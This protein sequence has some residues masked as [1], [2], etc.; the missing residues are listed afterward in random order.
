MDITPLALTNIVSDAS[1]MAAW[2]NIPASSEFQEA[3]QAAQSPPGPQPPPSSPPPQ[4]AS[5]EEE[6][7]IQEPIAQSEKP[8]P[9]PKNSKAEDSSKKMKK[10]SDAEPTTQAVLAAAGPTAP[11]TK[12]APAA[13]P[14]KSATSQTQPVQAA[15]TPDPKADKVS[16]DNLPKDSSTKIVSAKAGVEPSTPTTAP[17][18]AVVEPAS[19]AATVDAAPSIE[20]PPADNLTAP[21]PSAVSVPTDVPAAPQPAAPSA[22]AIPDA[23]TVAVVQSSA[24][25]M[26][27]GTATA[28]ESHSFSA[29]HQDASEPVTVIAQTQASGSQPGGGGTS[30]GNGGNNPQPGAKTEVFKLISEHT[31]RMALKAAGENV[32]VHLQGE[33]DTA[34]SMTVKSARGEVQAQIVTNNESLRNALHQ[35]RP[36]LAQTLETKGMSL[37]QM[38]AGFSNGSSAGKG[39]TGNPQQLN[40]ARTPT[41][42]AAVQTTSSATAQRGFASTKNSGVDLSI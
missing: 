21:A 35:N 28:Q 20:L 31:E 34:V 41:N 19:A 22:S 5:G 27:G 26:P 17:Q 25:S 15:K 12:D 10:T 6:Q 7:Q 24:A 36:Q 11:I 30:A 29:S 38:S 40:G 23:A 16:L 37:G 14:S 9:S 1:E 18:E 4:A 3:L 33:G 32:T 2:V 42:N 8:D 13:S 39:Q